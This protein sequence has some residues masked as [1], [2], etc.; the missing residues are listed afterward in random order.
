[1]P[2]HFLFGSIVDLKHHST[3]NIRHL[4]HRSMNEH[5]KNIVKLSSVLSIYGINGQKDG[6]G[7]WKI[8]SVSVFRI[9]KL[10]SYFIRF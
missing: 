10:S 5:E 7:G 4:L 2:V 6:L 9:R 3:S 8:V 1:V